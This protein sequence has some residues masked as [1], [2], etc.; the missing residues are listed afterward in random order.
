[1][2]DIT[3]QSECE[4]EG[5]CLWS[6]E[7]MEFELERGFLLKAELSRLVSTSHRHQCILYNVSK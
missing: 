3:I 4:T 7:A 6:R 1:M 5:E 2:A